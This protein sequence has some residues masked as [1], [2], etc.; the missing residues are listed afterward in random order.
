[1]PIGN[2][3]IPYD[4]LLMVLKASLSG[5]D[6]TVKALFASLPYSLMGTR[7]HFNKLI[8]ENWIE[9]HNGDADSR[10]KRVKPSEKLIKKVIELTNNLIL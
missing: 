3:F 7:S 10:I 5:E 4:I 6:L 1:M 8:K 2:S 9:L